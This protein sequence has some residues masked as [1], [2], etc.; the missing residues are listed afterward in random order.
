MFGGTGLASSWLAHSR[1]SL[2]FKMNQAFDAKRFSGIDFKM[3]FLIVRF[4]IAN[5]I[6]LRIDELKEIQSPEAASRSQFVDHQS[7]S[8]PKPL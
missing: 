1:S 6:A 3:E 2:D 5:V 4:I 7:P 8:S